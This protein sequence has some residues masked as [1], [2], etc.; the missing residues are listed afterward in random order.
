MINFV[1]VVCVITIAVCALIIK[2]IEN[3]F[4][5]TLAAVAGV[6]LPFFWFWLYAY[7]T[8]K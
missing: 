6:T 7:Y 1:A 2:L 5:K 4:V 8:S 3:V